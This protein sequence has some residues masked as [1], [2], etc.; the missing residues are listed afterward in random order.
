[1]DDDTEAKGTIKFQ[2]WGDGKLLYESDTVNNTSRARKI[3]VDVQGV[4]QMWLVVTNPVGS[5]PSNTH[6][7]W[8]QSY[9]LAA[10]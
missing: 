2:V 7:D 8:A 4:K 6:A 3:K 5:L 1:M 10:A 9:L